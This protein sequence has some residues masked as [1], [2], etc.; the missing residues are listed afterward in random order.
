GNIQLA[1]AN[2]IAGEV[3]LSA[4]GDVVLNNQID[5]LIGQVDARNLNITSGGTITQ[6]GALSVT[7]LTTLTATGNDITLD[8]SSNDFTSVAL[9]GANV[10][11]QDANAIE[12]AASTITGGFTVDTNGGGTITQ[13][14]ALSVTGLT[15]L[16]ATGNDIT[17][18]DGSNDFTSVALTGANVSIDR[19][20]VM[21]G[22][23]LALG[24]RRTIDNKSGG[25][26]T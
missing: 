21:E 7:D 22:A 16:T 9:T 1:E 6:S 19:K 4:V 14:G 26:I 15:T 18:T 17:L 25:T 3:T 5:T 13:S 20:S 8:N 11:I 2:Q 12:F 24:G 10:S 23:S